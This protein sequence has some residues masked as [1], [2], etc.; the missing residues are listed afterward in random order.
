VGEIDA[1]L[2]TNR[3]LLGLADKV[4]QGAPPPPH[5]SFLA[6][7]TINA[8]AIAAVQKAVEISGNPGL[9]RGNPLERHLR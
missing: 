5:E 4:D 3:L 2:Q 7:Y 6:K 9:T 8:N 1:L